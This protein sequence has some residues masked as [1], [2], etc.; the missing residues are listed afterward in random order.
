MP[1]VQMA[2]DAVFRRH[3]PVAQPAARLHRARARG[4]IAGLTKGSATR[5][6][7]LMA[8]SAPANYRQRTGACRH[9]HDAHQDYRLF[10]RQTPF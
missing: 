4:I 3:R 8:V 10:H 9:N 6:T 7:R 1:L 5:A 2:R